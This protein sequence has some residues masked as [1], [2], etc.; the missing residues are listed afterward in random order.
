MK[1]NLYSPYK[2]S[3]PFYGRNPEEVWKELLSKAVRV[4]RETAMKQLEEIVKER[5]ALTK[6]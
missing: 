3:N 2:P 6:K 5:K 4:D 1:K